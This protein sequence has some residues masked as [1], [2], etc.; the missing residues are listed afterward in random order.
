MK[1]N[2]LITFLLLIG[3]LTLCH[4]A[5][6]QTAS[7][8]ISIFSLIEAV[9]ANTSYRIYT[10]ID[11]PF[12]VKKVETQKPEVEHL[13][14]ALTG[15]NYQITIYQDYIFV[16][17]TAPLETS[18]PMSWHK[19]GEAD[20]ASSRAV[21]T[22]VR[23]TSENMVY[24]IGDKYK[25]SDKKQITLTGEIIDFKSG[26]PMVGINVIHRAP[27]VATVTDMQG[28]FTLLL[29][30]GHN[31]LEIS[32]VNIK[33]TQRQ[34]MLYAD[35][36]THIVLEEEDHLLDEVVITSGKVENVKGLQLGMEKFQPQLLKNIPTAMGEVDVLKM[37]QT[38]PGVKTVGEAS[39]G[40]NVRGGATDQ[41]LLLLNN[42]TIYNPNHLFG[43]FSAFNSDMVQDVELYKSSIPAQYG[44][45]I[46][47]VLNIT[48][49]EASKEKFTGAANIGLVTS[50]L[51]LEI[52]LV[53]E[54][55]SLLL[56]GRTTY[57]NWI[58]K[59]LP[60]KSGYKNGNAG[61]Y[62][63]GATWSYTIDHLNKVNVYGYYS[64]D[65]FEFNENEKYAY[66]KN[67]S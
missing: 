40:Y 26:Q 6:A 66:S 1:S 52:P 35:G 10:T 51:N 18:L 23:A 27:W 37:I 2:R 5:I 15:T 38:L 42:G 43:F 67:R 22:P 12:L 61:F 7:D 17:P 13:Q 60:E 21:I 53:K 19:D 24:D 14:K 48:G 20:K 44:G 50:K 3:C 47:S 59:R 58:M 31:V 34:Y 41:N 32:G 29:Q 16:L 57:S 45:R 25:P 54:K 39:N 56:S 30:Q 63:L 8:S 55:M 64:H 4:Q 49:K 28:R 33:D 65:R 62:D 11:K 9:E 36:T 46:S